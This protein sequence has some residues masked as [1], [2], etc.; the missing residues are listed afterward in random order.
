MFEKLT[1]HCCNYS[2]G[3]CIG[4]FFAFVSG[5]LRHK[6]YSKLANKP[7]IV[8]QGNYCVWLD[9]KVIPGIPETDKN[10]SQIE[11]WKKSTNPKEVDPS[12]RIQAAQYNRKCK[13]CQEQFY[14]NSRNK[15]Y[16]DTCR[17]ARDKMRFKKAN[18]QRRKEL[19]SR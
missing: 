16:C 18:K 9:K 12:P 15:I 1:R 4:A 19:V 10:L 5:E 2:D 7:C 17:K 6:V 8:N 13:R 14:T 3:I 11:K